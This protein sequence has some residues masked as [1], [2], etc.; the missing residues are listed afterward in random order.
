MRRHYWPRGLILTVAMVSH[1]PDVIGL[2]RAIKVT[3]HR[4]IRLIHLVHSLIEIPAGFHS[5]ALGVF[6][7]RQHRRLMGHRHH[8]IM[9]WVLLMASLDLAA[10]SNMA[11]LA[12]LPHDL[13]GDPLA[14][15]H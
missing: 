7:I 3:Q 12:R 11:H 14:I 5:A 1:G 4:L 10:N 8:S 6:G 15:C 9:L 13:A 2:E